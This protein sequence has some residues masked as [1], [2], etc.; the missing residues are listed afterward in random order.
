MTREELYAKVADCEE[1]RKGCGLIRRLKREDFGYHWEPYW[2]GQSP[3]QFVFLAWEPSFA[4]VKVTE[5][6]PQVGFF[7]E[8]LHYAIR[9]FLLCDR[10][11]ITN[12]AKCTIRTGPEC[13][14]TREFRYTRCAGFLRE[15][16]DLASAGGQPEFVAIGLKPW[17]FVRRHAE[18]YPGLVGQCSVS[19]ITH[20]APV[21]NGHFKRFASENDEGF[22]GFCES[23]GEDYR[24]WLLNAKRAGCDFGWHYD[25]FEAHPN[26][27]LWRLFKWFHQMRAIKHE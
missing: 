16:I 20:Y 18:L 26:Q 21:C 8:P 12:M 15:E 3:L 4:A 23:V 22:R 2:R 10:Y 7:N 6:Y 13:D 24:R 14:S 27:D 9:K 1:C 17:D 25:A 19:T 5:K 11:L